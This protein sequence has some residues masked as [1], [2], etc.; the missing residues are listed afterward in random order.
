MQPQNL[1]AERQS[2]DNKGQL[3][4]PTS[5]AL[6]T[7]H[8]QLANLSGGEPL[9][10][11]RVLATTGGPTQVCWR[12]SDF[13]LPSLRKF[14]QPYMTRKGNVAGLSQRRSLRGA[15]YEEL[16][17]TSGAESGSSGRGSEAENPKLQHVSSSTRSAR[18]V[19][20]SK[21]H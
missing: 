18:K 16:A 13:P 9:I 8:T 3:P 4:S 10:G 7:C 12:S 11:Y 6:A 17:S 21:L 5:L 14:S 2:L 15:A 20:H 19:Q 1:E